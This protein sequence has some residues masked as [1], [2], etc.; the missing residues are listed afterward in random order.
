MSA[1]PPAPPPKT[2][3]GRHRLLSP[4]AS[5]RVSPL[6]LGGMNFGDAWKGI[7]GECTKD[8]AFGILDHFFSAGGNFVDTA[9]NYQNEQSEAWI[10]EWMESKGVRDQMVVATKYTTNYQNYKGAEGRN[11]SNFAGN[12]T[13]SLNL[14]VRDSLTKLRTDY[15]DLLYVHW[16]APLPAASK[17]P[18]TVR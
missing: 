10:G 9:N 4:N 1:L 2:V 11:D 5:V 13:K 17:R 12:G 8:T 18:T 7:L 16:W 3:L 14:S 6:C 15:I